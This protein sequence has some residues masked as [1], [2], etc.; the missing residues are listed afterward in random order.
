MDRKA[1][2]VV[3]IFLSSLVVLLLLNVNKLAVAPVLSPT[4]HGTTIWPSAAVT[5]SAKINTSSAGEPINATVSPTVEPVA[6]V[7]Y[8]PPETPKPSPSPE[9]SPSE[10]V[11]MKPW[12]A[13][14]AWSPMPEASPLGWS[15]K[16]MK[17]G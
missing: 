10:S 12:Q 14:P 17:T 9:P 16:L 3:I 1:L 11:A 13:M 15:D 2:A 4:P 5:L 8:P 6:Q 7:A